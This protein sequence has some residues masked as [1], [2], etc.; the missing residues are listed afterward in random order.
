MDNA[1]IR[2]NNLRLL[3]AEHGRRAVGD[4]L[5][6]EQSQL[7]QIAGR[8]PTRDIGKTLAR[9]IEQLFEKPVGW[10]DVEQVRNVVAE[11]GAD[12]TTRTTRIP[13]LTLVQAGNPTEFFDSYAPGGGIEEIETEFEVGKHAFGLIIRGASMRR[14]DDS[15]FNDGDKVIFDPQISPEPGDFVV[16]KFASGDVTFKKYR[17]RG[18][19]KNG[20]QLFE[21]TPLNPDYAPIATNERDCEIVATMIEHRRY[22][23]RR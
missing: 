17:P 23:K 1:A 11:S 12:Y 20:E 14:D 10:L 7:S 22:R 16:A 4:R 6:M 18:I 21:L 5:G 2:R 9:K 19:G 3:I 13:I 8:N 15:G